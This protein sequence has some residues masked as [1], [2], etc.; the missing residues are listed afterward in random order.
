M[1]LLPTCHSTSTPEPASGE[2]VGGAASGESGSD[3]GLAS[4]DRSVRDGAVV[5]LIAAAVI[6][7]RAK[8]PPRRHDRFRRNATAT[9]NAP[10]DIPR[11]THNE[12]RG[13]ERRS[14]DSDARGSARGAILVDRI[15]SMEAAGRGCSPRTRLRSA[16]P[17]EDSSTP[18]PTCCRCHCPYRER[19]SDRKALD[20]RQWGMGRL[21]VRI[22]FRNVP[23][24]ASVDRGRWQ[25][26]RAKVRLEGGQLGR[27]RWPES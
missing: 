6:P 18:R 8:R 3:L 20:G 7:P 27:L 25:T 13:V 10:V 19:E 2:A 4:T 17:A 12:W 11:A 1:L 22:S 5:S 26:P 9:P 15:G 14:N 24:R 21:V 23:Q 16:D